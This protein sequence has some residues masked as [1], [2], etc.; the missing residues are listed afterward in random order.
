MR[1]DIYGIRIG[2]LTVYWTRP[3]AIWWGE[4]ILWNGK[5]Y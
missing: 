4:K 5:W 2:K 3:Y 1:T